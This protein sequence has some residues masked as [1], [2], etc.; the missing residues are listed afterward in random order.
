MPSIDI[1]CDDF[2]VAEPASVAARLGDPSLWR[3]WW[4]GLRLTPY[5]DRGPRGVRWTVA[6]ELTGTAELW[7]EEVRDGVVVHWYLRADPTGRKNPRRLRDAYVTAYRERLWA[8]KDEI[9]GGRA[10]GEHRPGWVAAIVSAGG[11][12]T[13]PKQPEGESMAEQ[14]TSSITVNASP[15]QIM[16]VIADFESYPEWADSVRETE[17]LSTGA[18]GRAKQVRFNVDAGAIKDEYSLD[19]TWSPTEVRWNLVEAK[20]LK[21]MDGAYVLEE[22]GDGSTEVTYRLTVDISIPM[23]GLLKRKA[24]KVIIDTALKGLKTRVES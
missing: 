19:Y 5:D 16:D 10:P 24:E 21:G 8:F 12:P 22:N 11:A 4:P 14:T 9:E 3:D 6:G 20:M 18:D 23:I 1:V 2:V 13:E 15:A 17:V 7:L